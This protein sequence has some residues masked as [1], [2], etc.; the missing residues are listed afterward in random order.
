MISVRRV[1]RVGGKVG[2]DPRLPCQRALCIREGARGRDHQAQKPVIKDNVRRGVGKGEREQ[3]NRLIRPQLRRGVRPAQKKAA[4]RRHNV[5]P[6]KAELR[7]RPV[8]VSDVKRQP[9]QGNGSVAGIVN[10]RIS[11]PQR[12][13]EARARGIGGKENQI[14]IWH[15]VVHIGRVRRLPFGFL[16]P[17]R[18]RP[19]RLRPG[20]LC[21]VR[22]RPALPVQISRA[23]SAGRV[24]ARTVDPPGT[25]KQKA[26]RKKKQ[27]H[28]QPSFHGYSLAFFILSGIFVR[29]ICQ[30][31]MCHTVP[32]APAAGCFRCSAP[33]LPPGR[34]RSRP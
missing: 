4:L 8:A 17:G 2:H 27:R 25:G 14:P 13:A 29:H 16:R 15:P 20:R 6:V 9:F 7:I 5:V 28:R 19:G 12:R 21:A 32:S 34:V 10:F 3:R 23:G 31:F 30:S 33:R 11:V 26:E 18:L 22:V 1:Q 24:R